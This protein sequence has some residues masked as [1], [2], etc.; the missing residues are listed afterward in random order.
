[1]RSGTRLLLLCMI[2]YLSTGC[3]RNVTDKK[4]V[5][6]SF[7]IRQCQTDLFASAVD[8][9]A[10][11]STREA[12]MKKWLEEKNISISSINL[13]TNFHGMV[14]AACDTCPT[15]DRY[16]ITTSTTLSDTISTTLRLLNL[17]RISCD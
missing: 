15:Q 8:V 2:M 7:D 1:M 17:E 6:Y 3:N 13:K 11:I 14:C 5:C 16:F 10:D 12:E 4:E 9:K